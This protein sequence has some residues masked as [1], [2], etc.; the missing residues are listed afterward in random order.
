LFD[1]YVW[2]H[3]FVF[4]SNARGSPWDGYILGNIEPGLGCGF[5]ILLL[6]GDDGVHDLEE[7]GLR[8]GAVVYMVLD[9]IVS[10][11][12]PEAVEHYMML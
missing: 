10:L 3:A 5:I 1:G 8:E 7:G 4:E 9:D 2:G 12:I 11:N 6:D